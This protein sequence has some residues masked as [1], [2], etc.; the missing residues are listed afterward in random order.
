[1]KILFDE[2]LTR[3][4]FDCLTLNQLRNFLFDL[5]NVT[6][7]KTFDGRLKTSAGENTRSDRQTIHFYKKRRQNR[8]QWQKRNQVFLYR[9]SISKEESRRE[10]GFCF[11]QNLRRTTNL[12]ELWENRGWSPTT[13]PSPKLRGSFVRRSE[14]KNIFVD[15]FKKIFFCFNLFFYWRKFH[16]PCNDSRRRSATFVRFRCS[17]KSSFGVFS[18]NWT[19]KARPTENRTFSRS[20]W[21]KIGRKC[22]SSK[23]KHRCRV[24]RRR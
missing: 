16:F 12:K 14:N 8:I 2:T 22:S 6:K 7:W 10:F 15:F 20:I 3:L 4:N 21:R 11:V 5:W 1:M 13:S 18:P 17:P 23:R 9:K 24:F 19:L